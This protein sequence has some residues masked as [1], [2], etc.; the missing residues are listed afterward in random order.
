[1]ASMKGIRKIQKNEME[2]SHMSKENVRKFYQAVATDEG[3]RMR[4]HELNKQHQD[5]AIDEEK[6]TALMEKLVLPIAAETGLAFTMEELRQ[7]NEEMSQANVNGELSS[8][9][10]DAISGGAGVGFGVCFGPGAC[11]AL[12]IGAACFIVGI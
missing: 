12:E 7:Y 8:D 3:L 6:K 11:I 5:E 1:M 9:E 4:L 2:G 10:L